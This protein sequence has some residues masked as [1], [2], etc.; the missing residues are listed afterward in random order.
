MI[1]YVCHQSKA[2]RLFIIQDD[3]EV[4]PMDLKRIVIRMNHLKDLKILCFPHKYIPPEGTHWFEIIDDSFPL[5]FIKSHGFSER[6]FICDRLNMIDIC[7]TMPDNNKM[8][9]RFIEFIYQTAMKSATWREKWSPEH[10]EKYWAVFGCY[11]HV[12]IYHTH[13]CGKR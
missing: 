11:F 8:E 13:L 6:V 7:E 9:K 1:E 5:P 2:D 12:S 4:M 3:V 10:K